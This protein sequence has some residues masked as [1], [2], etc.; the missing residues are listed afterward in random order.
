M[1]EHWLI[2]TTYERIMLLNKCL[3]IQRRVVEKRYK[4]GQ[5]FNVSSSCKHITVEFKDLIETTLTH[6]YN[7]Q[8]TNQRNET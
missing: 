6:S 1:E 3:L 7:K 2:T 4:T 5:I 8:S